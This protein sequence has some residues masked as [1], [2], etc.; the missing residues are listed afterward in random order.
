[1]N[2]WV[3]SH[4]RSRVP[5]NLPPRFVAATSGG[6]RV[7][8]GRR[9]AFSQPSTAELQPTTVGRQASPRRQSGDRGGS[10]K[11]AA[12]SSPVRRSTPVCSRVVRT[13]YPQTH[14]WGSPWHLGLA[15]ITH[16]ARRA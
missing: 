13:T 2:R 10:P 6:G 12:A 7:A 1:G 15:C 4:S 14:V 11:H 9:D 5:D 3:F 16:R 8:R